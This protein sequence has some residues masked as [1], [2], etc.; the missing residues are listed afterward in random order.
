P[1]RPFR[2]IIVPW[3]AVLLQEAKQAV[4]IPEKPLLILLGDFSLVYSAINDMFVK[5]LDR[6]LVLMQVPSLQIIFLNVAHDGNKQALKSTGKPFK[7]RVIR[8]LPEIVIQ[9]SDQVYQAFLLPTTT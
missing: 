1:N 5:S 9:I 8:V 7:L 3:N 6:L 2:H 4:S